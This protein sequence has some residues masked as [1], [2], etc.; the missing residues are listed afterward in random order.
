MVMVIISI[1]LTLAIVEV[2][3]GGMIYQRV[4]SK[5]NTRSAVFG[6]R[7]RCG[8]AQPFECFRRVVGA[9]KYWEKIQDSMEMVESNHPEARTLVLRRRLPEKRRRR[10]IRASKQKTFWVSA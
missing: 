9:G 8:T 10:L 5:R 7:P 6:G 4:A 2:L 1:A 3:F